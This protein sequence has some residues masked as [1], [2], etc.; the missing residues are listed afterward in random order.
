MLLVYQLSGYRCEGL[1]CSTLTYGEYLLF[2]FGVKGGNSALD[3]PLRR[4][5]SVLCSHEKPRSTIALARNVLS[6]VT[7]VTGSIDWSPF[8]FKALGASLWLAVFL[9]GQDVI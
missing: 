1:E 2:P 3:L 5:L 9:G 4:S 8:C 6:G 7:Q